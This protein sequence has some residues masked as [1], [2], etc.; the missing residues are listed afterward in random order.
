VAFQ[1]PELCSIHLASFNI[2]WHLT[3]WARV[4]GLAKNIAHFSWT[5]RQ[6]PLCVMDSQL[7]Q[8]GWAAIGQLL[9]T[10][11]E[12]FVKRESG[13]EGATNGYP[14]KAPVLTP[15][16]VL[17]HTNAQF[18]QARALY[19]SIATDHDRDWPRKYMIPREYFGFADSVSFGA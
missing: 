4:F 6:L 1:G 8:K 5:S 15:A 12:A 10:L 2:I 3:G 17:D 13:D 18:S 19:R 11:I 14:G 7:W 16:E 9:R